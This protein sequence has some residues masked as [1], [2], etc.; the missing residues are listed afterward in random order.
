MGT[1][2]IGTSVYFPLEGSS[3]GGLLVS[4][5][6]FFASNVQKLIPMNR[7]ADTMKKLEA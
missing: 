3:G 1:N 5:N 2:S 6:L 4:F 7:A